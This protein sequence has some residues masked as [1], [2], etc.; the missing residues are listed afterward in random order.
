MT[1]PSM[2]ARVLPGSAPV[3]L[4]DSS[5][6][7]LAGSTAAGTFVL[8]GSDTMAGNVAAAQSVVLQGVGCVA[9]PT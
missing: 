3:L 5:T 9:A 4:E 1:R 2:S 6:L 7:N 8:R